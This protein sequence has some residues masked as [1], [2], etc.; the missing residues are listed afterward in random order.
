MTGGPTSSRPVELAR[1]PERR[2]ALYCRAVDV[3]RLAAA[4]KKRRASRQ[5][6]LEERASRA[7]GHARTA[8]RVLRDEFGVGRVWLFGS[9]AWGR[10]HEASDID[11]AVE[12][13]A[14][15]R[16]FAA[17]SRISSVVGEQIDLV[18]FESC[19]DSLRGR[20]LERGIRVDD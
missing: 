14:P 5:A 10:V 13:L 20:I 2:R 17:L 12:G 18:P 6:R 3:D 9:L 19:S 4:W 1:A 15:E 8:A 16:T 7:R 11:L